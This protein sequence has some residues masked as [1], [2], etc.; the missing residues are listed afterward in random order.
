MSRATVLRGSD[1][2]S[3]ALGPPR[4]GMCGGHCWS[5]STFPEGQAMLSQTQRSASVLGGPRTP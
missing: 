5:F 1:R 4:E 2:H 3:S